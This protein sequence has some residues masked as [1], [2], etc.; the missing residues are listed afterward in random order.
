MCEQLPFPNPERNL[1][2]EGPNYTADAVVISPDLAKIL[3][4]KRAD[5]GEWAL[6]GGFID[7]SDTSPCQAAVRELLEETSVSAE[8]STGLLVFRGTVDDPR[9]DETA[10]I[11]TSAYLFRL[12]QT[13]T[14]KA[15][16]DAQDVQW[17]D[18]DILPSL[19][20]SHRDILGCALQYIESQ[21]V[22][23]VAGDDFGACGSGV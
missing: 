21:L 12:P 18:V 22:A 1:W 3:L 15:A 2:Y 23:E 4:I 16:D 14:A 9:N 20:A 17:H 6:P 19:Y 13:T 11:E 5:T 10:W 8:E 7:K